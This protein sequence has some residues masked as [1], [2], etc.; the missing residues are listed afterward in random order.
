MEERNFD[1][2]IKEAPV[3]REWL[4]SCSNWEYASHVAG[5]MTLGEWVITLGGLTAIVVA[6]WAM[7]AM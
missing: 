1:K 2:A 3:R 5:R 6:S 7:L 4:E